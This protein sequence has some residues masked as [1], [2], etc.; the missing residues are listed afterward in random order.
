MTNDKSFTDRTTSHV[1]Y[2]KNPIPYS[3]DTFGFSSLPAGLAVLCSGEACLTT[4]QVHINK[5][6]EKVYGLFK[7]CEPYYFGRHVKKFE[8]IWVF[9]C[10][11]STQYSRL[12]LL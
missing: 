7:D 1:R 6:G 11:F 5:N 2:P 3:E 12:G 8:L 4:D 9:A 10:Q